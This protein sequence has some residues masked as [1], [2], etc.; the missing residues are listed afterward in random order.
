MLIEDL[1]G[2]KSTDASQTFHTLRSNCSQFIQESAGL[3]LYRNLPSTYAAVQR[4]KVRAKKRPSVVGEALNR[5]FEDSYQNISQRAIFAHPS[6]LAEQDYDSEPYYVFPINGYKFIYSKEVSESTSGYQEVMSTLIEQLKDEQ[7]ANDLVSDLLKFTYT[8]R[9][10]SEGINSGC[11]I[12]LYGIPYYYA[13]R[14]SAYPDYARII[15][16]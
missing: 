16:G 1:L 15:S 8:S 5:A 3:P 13:V 14:C 2:T 4:V 9:N 10:L 12:I 11:E 6:F 7:T